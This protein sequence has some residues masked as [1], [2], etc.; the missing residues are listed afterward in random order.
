ML[1]KIIIVGAV[2]LALILVLALLAV[3]SRPEEDNQP[4]LTTPQAGTQTEGPSGPTTDVNGYELDDIPS[5]VRFDGETV[6]FLVWSDATKVE[7]F[8]NDMDG[9]M[10]GDAIY[11]R[12]LTVEE[13][14]GVKLEFVTETGHATQSALTKK[15]NN[16]I[17]SGANEYDIIGT[18]SLSVATMALTG[19]FNDINTLP[20]INLSKPWWPDALVDQCTI[21]N[22]LYYCSGDI[23]TNLLWMMTATYFN[24]SLITKYGL[25]DPYTLVKNNQWTFDKLFEMTTGKYEDNGNGVVDAED[26]F[27]FSLYDLNLDA[28]LTAAGFVA[29]E[30]DSSGEIILSPTA[31]NERMIDVLDKLKNWISLTNDVFVGGT[32]VREIFFQEKSIFHTDRVFIVAGKDNQETNKIEFSYGIVPQPKFNANQ[33]KFITN[34]GHP[35]TMY[36]ISTGTIANGNEDTCANTLECL[37]SESYRKVT[38]MVFEQTMK[39]RYSDDDVASQMYDILRGNISFDLGRLYNDTIGNF[40]TSMRSVI[41]GKAASYSSLYKGLVNATNAG[42]KKINEAYYD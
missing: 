18:Y 28:Y 13:R 11:E 36:A 16:D 22:K 19:A 29:L 33:D 9:D 40:Y 12:N 20:G 10:I 5:S 3:F 17:A 42:L 41:L 15:A 32:N 23:S 14:L 30:K 27:G 6:T 35:F 38:P 1:K 26:T 31:A 34:V 37:A 21:N 2:A 25:E 8:Y 39:I 7:F 4:E 24:K